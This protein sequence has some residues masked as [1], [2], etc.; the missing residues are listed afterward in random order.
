[1]DRIIDD[2]KRI[3]FNK[4]Q[5]DELLKDINCQEEIFKEMEKNMVEELAYLEEIQKKSN[6]IKIEIEENNS[7][8]EKKKK[9]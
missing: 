9:F 1:M 6:S 3:E 8:R 5:E 7:F 2:K 4:K